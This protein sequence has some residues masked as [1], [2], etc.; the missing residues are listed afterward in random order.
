MKFLTSNK[1]THVLILA[2]AIFGIQ[3]T[4]YTSN[5]NAQSSEVQQL[6]QTIRDIS[7]EADNVINQSLKQERQYISRI[8]C[9][10][11]MSEAIDYEKA[12]D[13][14]AAQGYISQAQGYYNSGQRRADAYLR[15]CR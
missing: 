13:Y 8:S 3:V 4:A 5:A 12:G 1:V 14:L 2:G 7:S 10:Q 6:N 11:L 9:S 15:N